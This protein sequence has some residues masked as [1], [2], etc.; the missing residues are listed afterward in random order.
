MMSCMTGHAESPE[1]GH[2]LVLRVGDLETIT[3][4]CDPNSSHCQ[5][6]SLWLCLSGV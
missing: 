4:N 1:E 5:V 3:I 6:G 2:Y